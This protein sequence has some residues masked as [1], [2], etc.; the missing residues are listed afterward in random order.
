MAEKVTL[1]AAEDQELYR[2]AYKSAFPPDSPIA[3]IGLSPNSDTSLLRCTLSEVNPDVLLLGTNRF[4]AC[5]IEELELIRRDQPR[6]GIALFLGC[7]DVEHLRHLRRLAIKGNGGVAVFLK[8]SLDHAEQLRQIILAVNHGQVILD[9]ALTDVM[10]AEKIVHPCTE[11]LTSRELE[12]LSLLS[13]GYTNGAIA[14]A[15]FID[16]RTVQ[17]HINSMYCKF[18]ERTDFNGMHR[19]VRAARIYLETIG[20]LP[21]APEPAG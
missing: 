6:I 15:L 7:Y 5:H 3:L 9:P 8:Q 16:I 13:R 17:K 12:V 4:S 14:E 2:E 10:F 1:Y 11:K 21:A 19:R 18:Q 20:E